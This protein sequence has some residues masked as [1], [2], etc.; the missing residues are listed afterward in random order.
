MSR[1]TSNSLKKFCSLL[2]YVE[3]KNR[4]LYDAIH[5]LCL[6]SLFSTR[7]GRSLTFL[8]PSP[9]SKM[10][11]KIIN[12]AY[13]KDP[14]IAIDHIKACLI[15]IHIKSLEGFSKLDGG[16]IKNTLEQELKIGTS[17][18][19]E[20]IFENGNA[21]IITDTTFQP[22]YNNSRFGVF[23]IKSGEI[24]VDNP[25][26]KP[27][28]DKMD[29]FEGSFEDAPVSGGAPE[30]GVQ[31][32]DKISKR[33][34]IEY[35]INADIERVKNKSAVSRFFKHDDKY[36]TFVMAANSLIAFIN[37]KNI[38]APYMKWHPNPMCVCINICRMDDGTFDSWMK[39]SD[40][41]DI[42]YTYDA[43]VPNITAGGEYDSSDI[44]T[45]IKTHIIKRD[46][47]KV[48]E[49]VDGAYNNDMNML[50]FDEAMFVMN[51]YLI[52]SISLDHDRMRQ[53]SNILIGH[54]C[55]PDAKPMLMRVTNTGVEVLCKMF[56]FV[57][58]DSF[59]W[60]YKHTNRDIAEVKGEF[61]IDH[62]SIA[63]LDFSNIVRRVFENK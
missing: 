62:K 22:L 59:M 39:D 44:V 27:K 6:S 49:L 23:I 21:T 61:P 19:T 46:L 32:P 12:A 25:R 47:N 40:A 55:P 56:E 54:Y 52:A 28:T 42:K 53:Y 43:Y 45:E 3:H 26:V 50:V 15:P 8:M 60:P 24:N 16:K 31:L 20:V 57:R 17:S 30:M 1:D 9:K 37:K 38:S 35:M 41:S 10:H 2:T 7:Q 5:D 11:T 4:D 51:L 58:S 48:M 34:F 36:N 63:V 29:T 13:S 14:N 18:N 33:S